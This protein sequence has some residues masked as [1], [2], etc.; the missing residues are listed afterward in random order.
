MTDWLDDDSRPRDLG[1]E[2]SDVRGLNAIASHQLADG[3]FQAASEVA[4]EA[5]QEIVGPLQEVASSDAP[6][7][8]F[9]QFERLRALTC[10]LSAELALGHRGA[11]VT[12]SRQFEAACRDLDLRAL[13]AVADGGQP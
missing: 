11:V 7:K 12:T 3:D 6:A 9:W 10:I 4:Q 8:F 13:T 1:I 2:L 5:L